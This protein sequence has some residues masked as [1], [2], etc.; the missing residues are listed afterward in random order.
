MAPPDTNNPDSAKP[1]VLLGAGGHARVII[2]Q[3]RLQRRLII[4]LLDDAPDKQDQTIESIEV[5]G[6]LDELNKYAVDDVLLVNA[7]GSTGQPTVRRSVYRR[8]IADGYR[9]ANIIHP[10]CVLSI[11]TFRSVCHGIQ[12]MAGAVAQ[13]GAK[14]GENCLINT[15]ATI[16]HDTTIGE[17]THVAPG[18]TV[19]GG[20]TIGGCCHIGAGATVVQGVKIGDGAVVGAGATV[21]RDVPAGQTVVGTPAKPI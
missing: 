9:F 12:V 2:S 7:I 18:A 6:G 17:H 4:G 3:L 13:P 1:V 19:C 20:V 15:G 5:L 14:L 11:D 16:D 10:E 21:L 8:F